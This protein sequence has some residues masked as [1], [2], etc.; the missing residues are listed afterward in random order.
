MRPSL[1]HETH[2]HA[3]L[4]ASTVADQLADERRASPDGGH[5]QRSRRVRTSSQSLKTCERLAVR[6][7]PA[8]ERGR[9]SH[10]RGSAERRGVLAV[11]GCGIAEGDP[12]LGGGSPARCLC[13][14]K[15]PARATAAA[16]VPPHPAGT[17]D[18]PLRPPG[19]RTCQEDG[20]ELGACFL[21]MTIVLAYWFRRLPI[22]P[23]LS[24]MV[25]AWVASLPCPPGPPLSGGTAVAITAAS[26]SAPAG[27]SARAY[28]R[29]SVLPAATRNSH[30]PMLPGRP[31]WSGESCLTRSD[32]IHSTKN[33][34][35]ARPQ[36]Y[37]LPRTARLGRITRPP[38]SPASDSRRPLR[39]GLA[40]S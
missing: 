23:T 10:P 2:A 4:L 6:P 19:D 12:P 8:S 25:K 32:S 17:R 35:G 14:G 16:W 31:A 13:T 33:L 39:C 3:T 34:S 1:P 7:Q 38:V 40:P 29:I 22:T 36:P 11:S 30:V 26:L 21:R 5:G 9:G 15:C 24:A 27:V 37:P 28:R 18:P 20:E